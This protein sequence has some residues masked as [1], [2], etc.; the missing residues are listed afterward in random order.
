MKGYTLRNRQMKRGVFCIEGFWDY[1]LKNKSS[2]LPVLDLLEKN[3]CGEYIYHR[4]GTR[5]EL[6]FMIRE[7]LKKKY[8]RRYPI[9]YLAS[10]GNE[11]GISLFHNDLVSIEDISDI[12][13][14]KCEK[15]IIYFGSCSTLSKRRKTFEEF[16]SKSKALA[17]FGYN[18]DVDYISSTA[19]ELLTLNYL[20]SSDFNL[21]SRGIESFEKTFVKDNSKLSKNLGFKV[22]RSKEYYPRKR[23]TYSTS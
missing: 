8:I 19:F 7:W 23:K 5:G 11:D 1:N 16:L 12:I 6:E 15:S 21:D 20:L 14:G 4:C 22:V 10:H 17:V 13:E 18:K 9:L 3:G 2:I